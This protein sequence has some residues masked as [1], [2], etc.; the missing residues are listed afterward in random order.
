MADGRSR[1]KP[2]TQRTTS[3]WDEFIKAD[4]FNSYTKK[5][6]GKM[7]KK[8]V[9]LNPKKRWIVSADADDDDIGAIGWSAEAAE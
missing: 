9:K 2:T 4:E 5:M 6:L 1:S 7:L 3:S 8:I